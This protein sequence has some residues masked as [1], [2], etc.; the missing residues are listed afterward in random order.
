MGVGGA[1]TAVPAE[2]EAPLLS[3]TGIERAFGRRKVLR[4]LDLDL[5]PGDVLVVTGA[6][7]AGKTT[8]LDILAGVSPPDA[9]ELRIGEIDAVDDPG[10]AREITGYLPD[11]F[12]LYEELS[13]VENLQ[14]VARLRGRPAG[15]KP[16][17]ESLSRTG[18]AARAEDPCKDLSAGM[19]RRVALAAALM[20]DPRLLV[21]D[22]P[23]AAMDS[24]GKDLVVATLALRR[25][26]KQ[27]ASVVATHDPGPI[28]PVMTH[29]L[30]LDGGRGE[31]R[32]V[33]VDEAVRSVD[34]EGA[35]RL[36]TPR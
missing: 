31:V 29:K 33:Q 14:L 10:A 17:L 23:L 36:A 35:I 26:R 9:G 21:M 3:A 18:V 28:A 34:R 8:L 19:R 32:R 11:A 20:H 24:D 1:A 13:A 25:D 22:E 27:A 4:G 2:S 5:G 15:L 6:N 30:A 12:P 16:A 7:G